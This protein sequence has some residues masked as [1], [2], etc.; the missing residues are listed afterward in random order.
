VS[1]VDA[2]DAAAPVAASTDTQETAAPID[3]TTQI[4]DPDPATL[5]RYQQSVSK[6]LA[7]TQGVVSGIW[8]TRSTLSVER[9]GDDAEVWPLI[10]QELER[11]PAL[12]T[13]RVQL[14]PR[15]GVEESVRW[16]QCR[17]Y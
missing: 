13:V 6:T 17:T 15:P 5:L 12:R 8:L 14:N 7:R 16:R 10:C 2:R 11:Y 4:A 3:A 1:A 9:S